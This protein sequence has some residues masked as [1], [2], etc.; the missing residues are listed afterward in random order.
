MQGRGRAILIGMFTPAR[1]L[2]LAV[3]A[4]AAVAGAAPQ[5]PAG[6]RVVDLAAAA[7]RQVVLDRQPGQ[8]IGHPTTVL[9]EDGQTM[10]AVYPLGHGQGGIVMKRSADGG[11]TWSD[12]LPV[13]AS[14]AT[15]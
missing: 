1:R 8:Y 4:A 7:G 13:P 12:R 3:L 2:A 10:I 6:P 5:Q 15:S 11:R 9:L 14:W